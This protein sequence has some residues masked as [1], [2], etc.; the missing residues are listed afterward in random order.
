ML[1][2][3]DQMEKRAKFK[4]ELKKEGDDATVNLY[5]GSIQAK[6]AILEKF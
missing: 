5:I 4:E 2:K 1:R 6:L 3:A